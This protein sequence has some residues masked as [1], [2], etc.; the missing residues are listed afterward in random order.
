MTRLLQQFQ[1]LRADLAGARRLT[2][3]AHSFLRL[4]VDFLLSRV[5]RFVKVPLADRERRI[6]LR[7]G[8]KLFYRLNR[9]DIYT[10]HEVWIEEIYRLPIHIQPEVIIDLGANIGLA[11]LWLA[12][13]YGCSHLLA[14]EPSPENARIAQHN[15]RHNGINAQVLEAAVGAEDGTAIFDEGPGATTGRLV[16]VP[17]DRANL[18]SP[19]QFQV[20]VLSMTSLLNLLPTGARLDLIKMDIEG[21]EQD[22]LSGDVSWLSKVGCFIAEFHPHLIDYPQLA[23][24]MTGAGLH[25]VSSVCTNAALGDV[26]DVFLGSS[27]PLAVPQT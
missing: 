4:S 5:M 12:R 14:V 10:I 16:E 7:D 21:G 2:A 23:A 17:E 3:D 15:F 19:K 25:A 6:R 13:R 8:T 9:A 11:G 20:R 24:V 1:D 27:Q 22:L 26:I 18:L